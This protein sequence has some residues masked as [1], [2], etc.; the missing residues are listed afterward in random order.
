[1][2]SPALTGARL[3]APGLTRYE[4]LL[5]TVLP[6]G[7]KGGWLAFLTVLTEKLNPRESADLLRAFELP[8]HET[9]GLKKLESQAKRLEST[10]KSARITRPSHVYDALAGATS[11]EVLMVLQDS[12]QRVVQDRIRTY[13]QKYLPLAQEIT[14]EQVAATGVKPGTPRFDKAF[15]NM[16]TSHLNAR[17][18]KIPP[19]EP[20]VMPPPAPPMAARGAIRK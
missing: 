7:T 17:P 11:D 5:H 20:E 12:A 8:K 2:I 3:N 6:P 14:E 13:F 10:L 1:M 18:K 4:K 9:E 15:R 16:V 19:P